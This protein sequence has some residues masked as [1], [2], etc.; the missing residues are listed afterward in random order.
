MRTIDEIWADM[1][2]VIDSA[3]GRRLT[4]DEVARYA[5]LEAELESAKADD[6]IRGKHKA[7]NT[8]VVPAGVPSPTSGAHESIEDAFTAYLRSAHPNADITELRVGGPSDIG[9]VRP[10]N[11]QSSSSGP[12]GGYLVPEGFRLK[13]VERMKS[14]GGLANVAEEITTEKGNNLPWPVIDDTANEGE[15]VDENAANAAGA[16][17]GLDMQDLGAWTYQAGGAG[18]GAIKL[19]WELMQDAAFDIEA[20]LAR[21]L[22]VRLGRKFAAHLISGSGV[23]QPKG[24][25]HGVTGQEFSS[26]PTYGDFVDLVTSVDHE[27]WDNGK[28]LFSQLGLGRVWKMVD[29]HG[30]PLWRRGQSDALQDGTFMGYPIQLDNGAGDFVGTNGAGTNWCAFGDFQRGYVVRKVRDIAVVVNPWSNADERQ[31]RYTAWMRADARPQD[32]F[33][34]KVG[35]G[36]TA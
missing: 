3:N 33:A 29:S 4:D 15:V 17:L 31:N 5:A 25:F 34:Y 19:P 28:W 6:G 10:S 22:G 20:L 1:Q 11:A 16:D 18:G 13:I 23:K 21:L 8:V 7:Y 26:A 36:Y 24:I 9:T 14:V 35:A 32:T 27:Y 2:A 12:A 30:D